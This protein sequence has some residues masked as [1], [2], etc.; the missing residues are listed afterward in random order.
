MRAI[1]VGALLLTAGA[2]T[3]TLT[4][5][6]PSLLFGKGPLTEE[7]LLGV[8]GE[9][10]ETVRLISYT[11]DPVVKLV[12]W[13]E[14]MD[15]LAKTS[16]GNSDPNADVAGPVCTTTWLCNSNSGHGILNAP[17]FCDNSSAWVGYDPSLTVGGAG[18]S[19]MSATDNG[20][21]GIV[22]CFGFYGPTRDWDIQMSIYPVLT[23][24]LPRVSPGYDG[25]YATVWDNGAAPYCPKSFTAPDTFGVATLSGPGVKT[26]LDFGTLAFDYFLGNSASISYG[27]LP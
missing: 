22:T 21:T 3:A 24:M 2:A 1:L 17:P 25:C 8:L 6:A 14:M 10:P 11:P 27:P 13:R 23:G 20:A 26:T 5:T 9:Q 4:A 18:S 7:F 12:P 16:L 19:Y 15:Q